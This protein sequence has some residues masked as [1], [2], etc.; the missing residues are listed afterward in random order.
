LSDPAGCHLAV[1]TERMRKSQSDASSREPVAVGE[2]VDAVLEAMR[3]RLSPMEANLLREVAGLGRIIEQV[4][5]GIAEVSVEAIRGSHLP[6]ASV[7][8]DAIVLHTAD[9]TERIL[10]VCESLD[11]LVG[12][13]PPDQAAVVQGATTAIYEACSFQDITSQRIM[14]IV[15]ALQ[16][17]EA[18][19]HDLSMAYALS[20]LPEGA[21]PLADPT[22]V[23]DAMLLNGPSLPAQA[24]DQSD[25]DKLMAD[26]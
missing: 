2:V 10:A 13:L 17:I 25:I 4:K 18:K 3:G 22:P 15:K 20:A 8:L 23:G 5:S 21:A 7:E 16:A 1:L 14:K 9:A 26:F 11:V 24:M 12:S 19:V 6:S